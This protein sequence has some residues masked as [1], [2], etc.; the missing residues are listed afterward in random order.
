MLLLHVYYQ[1]EEDGEEIA[2]FKKMLYSRM[3]HKILQ[4]LSTFATL[5]KKRMGGQSPLIV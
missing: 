1:R 4:F 3:K 2:F 5:G